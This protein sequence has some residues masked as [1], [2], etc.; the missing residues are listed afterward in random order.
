MT[1]TPKRRQDK[2]GWAYDIEGYAIAQEPLLRTI[3]Y[4]GK[5]VGIVTR[6]RYD[7]E[8]LNAPQMLF[9]DIDLGDPRYEDGCFVKTE[10]EAL[11]GLRD[12]VKNP[13]KWLPK[14][15]FSVERDQWI[16]RHRSG[17]GFRVYRTAG[18]L[19]YICTT[20]QWWAGRDFEDDLMRFV[21]TD[22]RYRRICRS[23]QTF[24]VRLTPKPWRIRQ[25]YIEH[26]GRVEWRNKPGEGIARTAKYVTTVG[27]DM[28]LPEFGDLLS[29]HD[30]T[31]LALMD[32][33]VKTY[34]A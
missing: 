24:R 25:E 29:V 9:I 26:S 13:M 1:D 20:H 3:K 12:A 28:V 33:G 7:A 4:S 27:S 10:K 16:D 23:Q 5:E 30:S 11:D 8:V 17:L 6:C 14:Y 31:T 22:Y 2:P 15:G 32:R 34:L 21:Y 18:G 19:R